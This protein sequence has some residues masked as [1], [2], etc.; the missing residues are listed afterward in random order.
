M[1]KKKNILEQMVNWIHVSWV[2]FCY[3]LNFIKETGGAEKEKD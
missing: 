1:F 2:D 3:V